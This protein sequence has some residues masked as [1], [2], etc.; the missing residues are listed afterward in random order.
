MRVKRRFSIVDIPVG[1]RIHAITLTAILGLIALALATTSEIKTTLV[2][3]AEARTHQLVE[4]AHGVL[5]DYYAQAQAG[6][7]TTEQAKAEALSAIKAM[8]FDNGNY[9]SVLDSDG[10]Q[11]ANEGRPELVGKSGYD[12]KNSEGISPSRLI[13]EFAAANGEGFVHYFW[14]KAGSTVMQ[15]KITY[16]M[17]F[18]PWGWT[19]SSGAYLDDIDAKARAGM[20][21]T[22]G[23][24]LAVGLTVALVAYLLARTIVGP[25]GRAVTTIDGLARGDLQ[26][27]INDAERGDELGRIGRAL[28]TLKQMSLERARL[29]V[30]TAEVR[31]TSDAERQRNEA[32][33]ALSSKEQAHVIAE[34][35]GGLEQLT[36]GD[37]TVR[38][39]SAFAPGSEKLRTDFNA[40]LSQL[41]GTM[42]TVSSTTEEIRAGAQEVGQAAD[43]LSRRTEQQ[44]ASLEETAA[45]LDEITATVK[46]TSEGAVHARE[47]VST[48]KADAERSGQVVGQAVQAMT[49]I[50]QSSQQVTQIIGVIDEIAFQTNLLALNAGVEAAR[51][52]EAGRGF[53]VVASEVRA[54]AQRSAEAAKEIKAL[55][56]TSTGQVGE[57][58]SLVAETGKAL[59]RIATQV[60]EI[61]TIVTDIAASAQEQAAGLEQVNTAVNQMDQVTQ[62]NAAMVEQSTAASHR[63]AAEA[64]ELARLIGRF[65]V[66]QTATRRAAPSRAPSRTSRAAVPALKTTG[67]GG[68]ARKADTHED[69]AW[70]EF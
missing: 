8:R 38:I 34:L 21:T 49:A 66:G 50:E 62:Q 35:G 51:A 64:E 5:N 57:G 55:I 70:E 15:P 19:V 39:G 23:I 32:A 47:V 22:V 45:A 10:I 56:S 61:N 63:L 3:E 60:S 29:E 25:L 43:D 24:G 67:R 27:E 36:A 1:T 65:Q 37:L 42:T 13:N 30:E 26:A 18:K 44:A 59:E 54:L 68:A 53:A 16:V 33:V 28:I 14:T 7:L 52:G 6:R 31:K 48:A 40:A 2:H 58:V 46:K 69:T 9:Y 4:S 41:Q 20:W 12:V 17:S 11:L